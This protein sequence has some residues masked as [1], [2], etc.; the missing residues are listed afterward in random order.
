MQV[1]QGE[2]KFATT[3]REIK[4]D[5]KDNT[6]CVLPALDHLV[7][8]Q[9]TPRNFFFMRSLPIAAASFQSKNHLPLLL[10]HI[11]VDFLLSRSAIL[12]FPSGFPVLLISLCT[13]CHLF[14]HFTSLHF[15]YRRNDTRSLFFFFSCS[16]SNANPTI[17]EN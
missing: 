10:P 12:R 15:T 11:L 3:P 17:Q 1:Y 5:R 9:N 16:R 6:T 13:N 2:R 8:W 7:S 14:V 4:S